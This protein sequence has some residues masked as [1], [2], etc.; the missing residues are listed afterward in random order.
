VAVVRVVVV[1]VV[2]VE[3]VMGVVVV[4]FVMGLVVVE[5]F[6]GVVVDVVVSLSRFCCLDVVV[7]KVDV[8]VDVQVTWESLSM[9][10]L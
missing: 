10:M 3:N 4:V 2:F 5:N 7:V 9:S 1:V 8:V 6:M